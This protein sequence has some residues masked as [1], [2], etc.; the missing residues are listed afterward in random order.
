M[1]MHFIRPFWLLMLIP[2]VGYLFWVARGQGLNSSWRKICDPHLLKAL[3]AADGKAYRHRLFWGF[4]LVVLSVFVIALAG[5]AWNKQ[6]LPVYRQLTSRVIVL[7]LSDAMLARD[8]KPNRYT[9]ARYKALDLLRQAN[10]SQI[11]MVSFTAQAF[12]VS[13]L[14]QDAKTIAAMLDDLNPDMMPVQGSNMNAGLQSASNLLKQAH[15]N[16]GN[17]ILLTASKPNAAAF[18]TAEQL[19]KSGIR[20]DVIGFGKHHLPTASL[21]RLASLGNGIYLNASGND[22]DVKTILRQKLGKQIV[23]DD[24]IHQGLMY[25]DRGP[26]LCLLLLPLVLLAFRRGWFERL[27]A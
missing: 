23:K 11:G 12:V 9:R 6:K 22:H 16:G 3:I 2:L 1:T 18:E 15:V 26:W 5:P 21:K 14:T 8:L 20:L 10:N 24:N 13:P 27:N 19:K 17:I 4:A 25:K 7:D